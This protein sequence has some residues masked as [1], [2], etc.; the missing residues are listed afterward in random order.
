[1]DAA[2][3]Q[4]KDDITDEIGLVGNAKGD[5]MVV[6]ASYGGYL[7]INFGN[8]TYTLNKGKSLDCG[9]SLCEL[10]GEG[11]AL[12]GKGTIVRNNGGF[13]S[14]KGE[15]DVRGN[16]ECS[17][18]EY[19]SFAACFE[20]DYTG[21][22]SGDVKLSESMLLIRGDG[23]KVHIGQLEAVGRTSAVEVD[24]TP[25]ERIEIK[26]VHSESQYPVRTISSAVSA[27]SADCK[28]HSHSFE[29]IEHH[30][31]TC[32]SVPYDMLVCNCGYV[33]TENLGEEYGKCPQESIHRIGTPDDPELY[34]C[35]LCGRLYYDRE[36]Q[37]P[38]EETRFFG[39][40]SVLNDLNDELDWRSEFVQT[41]SGMAIAG[42][43]LAVVGLVETCILSLPSILADDSEEWAQVNG[44]L[45]EIKSSLDRIEKKIDKL[46]KLVDAVTYKQVVIERNEKFN[47]LKTKSVPAFQ[48][49]CGYL[50]DSTC[51][52]EQKKEKVI[53]TLKDWSANLYLGTQVPDITQNLIQQF[54]NIGT[55]ESVPYS[56]EYVA[57]I[58]YMWEHDGFNFVYQAIA[59]DVILSSISYLMSCCYI[60]SVKE[61]NNEDLRKLDLEN[62]KKDY[63]N[64]SAEVR[65]ELDRMKFRDEA[66]RCY[67]PGNIRFDRNVAKVDFRQWFETH[68]GRQFPRNNDDGKAS[69]SCE[70]MLKD[71]GLSNR[72]GLTQAIAKD[73]YNYYNRDNKSNPV[74]I[75]KVLVDSVGFKGMPAS[76]DPAV[77]F[78]YRSTG[79][80][81]IN[82]ESSEP[83]YKIFQWR[84]LRG[85]SDNDMFGIRTGLN[86]V[87]AEANRNI[88]YY[89]D[90]NSRSSGT[91][92]SLGQ[93]TRWQWY[94]LL[95]AD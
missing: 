74:S 87:C 3:I 6:D 36:A 80:D 64:Y 65:N 62:F 45:D 18:N 67:N 26:R 27:I 83:V 11:G 70:A 51:T 9:S 68:R 82:G 17:S 23:A 21:S 48:L 92:N 75:Y 4:E 93:K 63:K 76:F 44:K 79:F 77:L 8:C 40:L 20:R 2:T 49:M 81:H 90:I 52:T 10:V 59:R 33:K 88:L 22:F 42:I 78:T 91:I 60:S 15:L 5:G 12:E 46:A 54:L 86:D 37:H 71:L 41:K 66:Y 24:C 57:N 38:Y 19:D 89:C 29:S 14:F 72:M 73:I 61:Y 94:T 35:S 53:A 31:A 28:V 58:S 56:L 47:Y 34:A 16:L 43:V 13:L 32:I 30:P 39:D 95:T 50:K 69:A 85:S 25:K 84:S 1:M 55:G 7:R